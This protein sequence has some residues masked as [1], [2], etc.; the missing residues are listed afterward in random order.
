MNP[1]VNIEGHFLDLTHDATGLGRHQARSI[2]VRPPGERRSDLCL[3][4]EASTDHPDWWTEPDPDHDSQDEDDPGGSSAALPVQV[5][6]PEVKYLDANQAAAYL[7]VG[8]RLIRR[9]AE[10]R[11]VTV[12]KVGKY[13]RFTRESLDAAVEVQSPIDATS[14]K[15]IASKVNED[16]PV[17]MVVK[18]SLSNTTNKAHLGIVKEK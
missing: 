14:A 15:R 11:R 2:F 7:G 17:A 3:A 18:R 6:G 1:A 8:P 4:G 13:R 12:H 5:P 16:D 10:Q 9:L